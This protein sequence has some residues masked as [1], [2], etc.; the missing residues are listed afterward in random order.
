MQSTHLDYNSFSH[1]H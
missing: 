1:A